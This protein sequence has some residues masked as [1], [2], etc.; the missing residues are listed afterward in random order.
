MHEPLSILQRLCETYEE[1]DLLEK[2]EE[3][4]SSILRMAYVMGFAYSG[5]APMVLRVKKPF[6]SLLGETYE[7]TSPSKKKF[8]YYAEH[9]SYNPSIIATFCDSQSFKA[10]SNINLKSSFCGK[11]LEYR[12]IGVSHIFL[13][14][15]RDHYIW[16]RPVT[17]IENIIGGNVYVENYGDMNFTN[18]TTHETG[19]L[20]L[21]KSDPNNKNEH[22]KNN[23]MGYIKNSKGKI[24]YNIIG[25]LDRFLKIV[26]IETQKQIFIWEYKKEVELLSQNQYFFDDFALQ[27]NYLNKNLLQSIA[28][29][30]SRLRPD[31][32]AL[33]YLDYKVC[34]SEKK[35]LEEKEKKLKHEL[36]ENNEI[37]KP[38]WFVSETDE[39]TKLK[40]FVFLEDALKTDKENYIDIF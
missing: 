6:D 1:V 12:P 23:A 30:D 18:L 34:H 5:Y 16:T 28:S 27:L 15:S 26:E 38:K 3:T 11:Y 37:W 20:S 40:S 33:E 2:T 36:E 8:R 32:R 17:N 22:S 24:V 25:R 7:F 4:E 13:N 35:R 14:K 21:N 19:V 39:V 10:W 29:T 9:V 31:V